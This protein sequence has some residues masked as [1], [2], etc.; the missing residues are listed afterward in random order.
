MER[1]GPADDNSTTPTTGELH[2]WIGADILFQIENDLAMRMGWNFQ[3]LCAVDQRLPMGNLRGQRGRGIYGDGLGIFPRLGRDKTDAP[4]LPPVCQLGRQHGRLQRMRGVE[5]K[6]K[7]GI[8]APGVDRLP[9]LA[10]PPF[11]AP[12]IGRAIG[13]LDRLNKPSHAPS[14]R[15][16]GKGEAVHAL[17]HPFAGFCGE[18]R[19]LVTFGLQQKAPGKTD[20]RTRRDL[21]Q[22]PD[23]C[24]QCVWPRGKREIIA[25]IE[26]SP[27]RAPLRATTAKLSIDIEQVALVRADVHP[28]R[29]VLGQVALQAIRRDIG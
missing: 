2:L 16:H 12:R 28:D 24:H 1:L 13:R 22:L 11:N 3:R 7:R 20:L 6:G 17:A 10:L 8:L 26:P 21:V 14:A 19:P 5:A 29:G 27:V 25:L 9:A 4:H 15:G 23:Q 18:Q